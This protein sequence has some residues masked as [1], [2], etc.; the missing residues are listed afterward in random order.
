MDEREKR[1]A[2]LR[3]ELER[4]KSALVI[5][6]DQAERH[7]I[8]R[9]INTCISQSLALIDWRLQIYWDTQTVSQEPLR[10]R[11]AGKL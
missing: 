4:L 6:T 8:H 5:T 7:Q 2:A 10:E 11:Q 9:R 3:A 1:A